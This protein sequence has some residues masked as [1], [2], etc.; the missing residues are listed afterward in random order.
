[1]T[2]YTTSFVPAHLM[3]HMGAICKGIGPRRSLHLGLGPSA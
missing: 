3:E 1:M 2:N